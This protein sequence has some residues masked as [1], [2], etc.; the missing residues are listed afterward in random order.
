MVGNGARG[1]RNHSVSSVDHDGRAMTHIP[2]GMHLGLRCLL[3]QSLAD[4]RLTADMPPR[5]ELLHLAEF[6]HGFEAAASLDA[7]TRGLGFIVTPVDAD[8]AVYADPEMLSSAVGHL[9]QNA[10][11]FTQHHTEVVLHGRSVAGRVFIEI[12]DH[13]GGLPTGA[14]RQPV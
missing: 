8:I 5:F 12:E 4:V 1:R 3:D 2:L 14:V 6:L 13:C 10:F 9:L 11:K 7:Q